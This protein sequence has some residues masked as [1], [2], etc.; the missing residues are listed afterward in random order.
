MG[1]W[2]TPG[3]VEVS[4]RPKLRVQHSSSQTRKK[5]FIAVMVSLQRSVSVLHIFI[6][7][8]IYIYIIYRERELYRYD[9]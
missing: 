9:I 1:I 5:F 4:S 6:C 3:E 7:T 2:D 8:Y